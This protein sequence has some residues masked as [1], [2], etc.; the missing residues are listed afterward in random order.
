MFE[1]Q[2]SKSLFWFFLMI[3]GQTIWSALEKNIR[4]G[5]RKGFVIPEQ[6]PLLLIKQKNHNKRFGEF[7][8]KYFGGSY[9][10]NKLKIILIDILLNLWHHRVW[11]RNVG[12]ETT[13]KLEIVVHSSYCHQLI[14]VQDVLTK[15][16]NYT[17]RK[18]NLKKF[19][20]FRIQH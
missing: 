3:L 11:Q 19:S 13:S 9:V 2:F 16:S 12:K 20:R 6:F 18:K 8:F 4:L 17:F 7:E 14:L 15:L 5:F 10:A 1:F